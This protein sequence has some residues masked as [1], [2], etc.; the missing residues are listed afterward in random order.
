MMGLFERE[1]CPKKDLR[2]LKQN[3]SWG[4]TGRWSLIRGRAVRWACV[5]GGRGAMFGP[6]SGRFVDSKYAVR[7]CTPWMDVSRAALMLD[8]IVGRQT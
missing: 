1:D 5:F 8:I 4:S 7:C 2:D 6:W 3:A